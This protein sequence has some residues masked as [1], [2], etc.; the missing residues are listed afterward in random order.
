MST[1]EL[2]P[3]RAAVKYLSLMEN[4]G[5]LT[6][7]HTPNS[8]RRDKI[9]GAKLKGMGT[10]PGMPDM[11][12]LFP[13]ART[14]FI[15]LKSGA[16][17]LSEAQKRFRNQAEAFGFPYLEAADLNQVEDITRKLIAAGEK[18]APAQ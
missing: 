17:R 2:D 16:G 14:A 4:L 8:E 18:K 13:G 15:E 12:L 6:Y 5:E 10:R 1:P 3:Q 7:W 11:T 9:T